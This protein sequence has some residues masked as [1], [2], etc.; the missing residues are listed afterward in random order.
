MEYDII[1]D[2]ACRATLEVVFKKEEAI[3][4]IKRSAQAVSRN[5][6]I[7]GFRKGKAP[8]EVVKTQYPDAI[9]EEVKHNTIPEVVR[10]IIKEEKLK[11]I[12]DVVYDID[13]L[14]LD[15]DIAFK[16][17][18]YLRPEVELP[19]LK[20]IPLDAPNEPEIKEKEIEDTIKRVAEDVA[21]RKAKKGGASKS[22]VVTFR[23]E[24]EVPKPMDDGIYE[25]IIP[26]EEISGS[27]GG[28][29][30]GVCAGDTRN[31]SVKYSQQ[32]KEGRREEGIAEGRVRVT[33]VE[34]RR[35]P[36]DIDEI[37]RLTGFKDG[38]ALRNG[39]R[40]QIYNSKMEMEQ[41]RV[42]MTAF[43][44]IVS[45]SKVE[46]PKSIIEW[47]REKVGKEKKL[48]EKKIKELLKRRFVF[49]SLLSRFKVVVN[50]DELKRETILRAQRLGVKEIT[51]EFV[52]DTHE[53]ILFR[54][55]LDKLAEE[56]FKAKDEK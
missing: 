45:K 56:I 46:L 16:A 4:E 13:K 14:N 40:E 53:N 11:L 8:F 47:Y 27:V 24:G 35:I 42:R 25:V 7:K 1:Y 43:A 29:L 22:D 52:Y 10:E 34:E 49:E 51:K 26:E 30:C 55:T 41:E 19:D 12:D 44:N 37:A 3:D 31:I 2:D 38:E 5:V 36:D 6:E 54:K 23:W 9:L 50:E 15:G 28:Q 17:T 18:L 39:I 21:P 20:S 33:K 48:D 32:D